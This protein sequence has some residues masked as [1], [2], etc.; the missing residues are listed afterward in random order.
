MRA[1]VC[2]RAPVHSSCRSRNWRQRGWIT[3]NDALSH[4]HYVESSVLGKYSNLLFVKMN[5]NIRQV[6]IFLGKYS[7]LLFVKMNLNIRQMRF[8]G[9]R[10][11]NERNQFVNYYFQCKII[12]CILCYYYYYF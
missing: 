3:L 9:R 10:R 2:A 6:D 8:F 5:L 12:F 4:F 11:R 7:N 1:C